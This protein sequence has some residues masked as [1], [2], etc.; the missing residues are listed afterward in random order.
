MELR[1]GTADRVPRAQPSLPGSGARVLI[2]DDH[3]DTASAMSCLL[4]RE[5]YRVSVADSLAAAVEVVTT[6]SIE[7]VLSDITLPDGSGLDLMR[8]LR[9]HGCETKAIA[10]SGFGAAHDVSSS[11]D[12]GF[13]THLVKPVDIDTLLAAVGHALAA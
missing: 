13:A 7:L 4:E 9:D 10:I 5:G 8:R 1:F 11:L 12:A 3:A 6:G 2:V